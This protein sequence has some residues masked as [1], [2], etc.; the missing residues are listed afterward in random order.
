MAEK[1]VGSMVGPEIRAN[2]AW[3]CLRQRWMFIIACAI[4]AALITAFATL[5][6]IPRRYTASTMLLS[7]ASSAKS[8]G[9]SAA[10]LAMLGPFAGQ[11]DLQGSSSLGYAHAVINSRLVRGKI[12][13]EFDLQS[14]FGT[15]TEGEAREALQSCTDIEEDSA[16]QSLKI[17]VTLNGS[18]WMQDHSAAADQAVRDLAADIANAY[19]E[20]LRTESTRLFRTDVHSRRDFVAQRLKIAQEELMAAENTL[21]QWQESHEVV[22]PSATATEMTRRLVDLH[23]QQ[24]QAR[25]HAATA[26]GQL[27]GAREQL[28]SIETLRL[29]SATDIRNPQISE[30]QQRL[31]EAETQLALAVH[32]EGASENHPEVRRHRI[33]IQQLTEQLQKALE[34]ELVTQQRVVSAS[35]LHDEANT[36]LLQAQLR[37]LSAEAETVAL[38][39]AVRQV[40]AQISEIPQAQTEFARMTRDVTVKEQVY[41]MLRMEY[42]KTLIDEHQVVDSFMVLDE[43]I[44]PERKS[45]PKVVIS[46]AVAGMAGLLFAMMWVVASF[47][48]NSGRKA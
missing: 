21:R 22:A 27:R 3:M 7:N 40:T 46:T 48:I 1:S 30:L 39:T 38:E 14:F 45:G 13:R 41:Q 31:T 33:T 12:V 44:A 29:S 2:E 16:Q 35:P 25:I 28:A 11:L 42:E 18:P 19:R 24:E 32:G 20:Q 36:Q 34:D 23:V 4:F 5:T 15:D 6:L 43:A 10:A 8:S 17:A 47:A 9:V 37:K 26:T